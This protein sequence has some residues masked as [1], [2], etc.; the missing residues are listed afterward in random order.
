MANEV[1]AYLVWLRT[2]SCLICGS[3]HAEPHHSPFGKGMGQ[4]SHDHT[5]VPL[6]RSHH[7][8]F[9]DVS[10]YFKGWQKERRKAWQA[11]HAAEY[12]R[13]Y[14]PEHPAELPA[15]TNDIF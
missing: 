11:T 15:D 14:V 2:L 9:H 12:V 10:G 7:R 8:Q 1:P 4:R 6:C 3:S 13:L 5:S